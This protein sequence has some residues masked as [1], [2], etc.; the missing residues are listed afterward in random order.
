VKR[1][2]Y[3]PPTGR[4]SRIFAILGGALA[5]VAVFVAIP[6]SQRL[7]DIFQEPV[8]PPLEEVAVEPPETPDFDAT[9]PPEEQ[10]EEPPPEMVEEP[11]EMDLGLDLADLPAG[12]GGGFLME[13]PKFAV[14]EAADDMMGDSLDAPPQAVA[15]FPPVYPPSLLRSATGGRVQVACTIDEAGKVVAAS[16]RQSSGSA[17]LDKAA[18]GA[19]NRW[20]FKAAT[21]GGKAVKASCVVP[22]TFE[23]KK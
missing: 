5:T 21:R 3:Q 22:F 19:V 8:A 18:I 12:A 6:L 20:K 2:V 9:P 15:K 17:E 23:V 11:A 4:S 1:H 16:I 14:K 10:K 7:N 13:I